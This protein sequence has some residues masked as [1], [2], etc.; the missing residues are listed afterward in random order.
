MTKLIHA[1]I[2]ISILFLLISCNKSNINTYDLFE[3]HERDIVVKNKISRITETK[4]GLDIYGNSL[5]KRTELIKCFNEKGYLIMKICP[6]Y[7]KSSVECPQGIDVF[8]FYSSDMSSTNISNGRSDTT[9][10]K[11]D[12]QGNLI[13]EKL[14]GLIITRKYDINNNC[15]ETCVKTDYSETGCN[16]SI[17]M[18]DKQNRVIARLDSFGVNSN[19]QGIK[20]QRPNTKS[21]YE[22]DKL[23][24][25]IFDGKIKRV[26]N[27]KNQLSELTENDDG[28]SNK[29]LC[30]YNEDGNRVQLTR[31]CL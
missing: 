18:Y 22:Y 2:I 8:T 20:Y 14:H 17:F 9:Y 1:S 16:Y 21:L 3:N 27:T 19:N 7:L 23:G 11:Y 12:T 4:I 29:Y 15:T 5:W 6:E 30:F 26:F 24:R 31:V 13:T 10:Y 28:F 25:I